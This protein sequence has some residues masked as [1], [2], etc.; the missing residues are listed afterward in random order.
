MADRRIIPGAWRADRSRP[1]LHRITLTQLDDD[2]AYPIE[3]AISPPLSPRR[4]LLPPTPADPLRGKRWSRAGATAA[5]ALIAFGVLLW[6]SAHQAHAATAT[7][8]VGLH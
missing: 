2:T 7:V 1:D 4:P 5:I 3:R 6:C 8:L